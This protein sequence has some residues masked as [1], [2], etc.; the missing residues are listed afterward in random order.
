MHAHTHTHRS[1]ETLENSFSDDHGL[2][3]VS[4]LILKFNMLPAVVMNILILFKYYLIRQIL[5]K[6]LK[7]IAPLIPTH[8]NIPQL[9]A[10]SSINNRTTFIHKE[11][12]TYCLLRI[13][14]SVADELLLTLC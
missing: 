1:M 4:A 11:P 13:T 5:S 7:G 9:C 3:L 10:Q 2:M 6:C 12:G 8:L 14:N